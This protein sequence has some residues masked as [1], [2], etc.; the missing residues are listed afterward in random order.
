MRVFK[1]L[2]AAMAFACLPH[3]A[4]AEDARMADRVLG[5]STAPITVDE[6]ASMACS[7]CAEFSTTTL[8]ELKKRYVDTG[9]VRFVFHDF[10]LDGTS[11]KAAA[12][13]RCMP[14]D[15]FFPFINLLYGN[16]SQWVT[17]KE[18]EKVIVQYAKLG[19]LP[20]E[21]AKSCMADNKLLDAIIAERTTAGEKYDVQATP[22][23][24]INGGAEKIMGGRPLEDF[25]TMFDRLLAAKK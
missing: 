16:F 7:H 11:L 20:E 1:L 6:F 4:N 22:T 21:T 15:Q 13:A 17:A 10:P 24:I 25:T 19:G 5:V 2:V 14:A 12:V 18:P 3:L 9:K 8:P 23:F